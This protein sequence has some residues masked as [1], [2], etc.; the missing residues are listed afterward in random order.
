MYDTFYEIH[1]QLV[2]EV[3]ETLDDGLPLGV[4]ANFFTSLSRFVF[5]PNMCP[6]R[7]QLAEQLHVLFEVVYNIQG[8]ADLSSDPERH[9][10][11]R[12]I[13]AIYVAM[14]QDVI[15]IPLERQLADLKL[16]VDSLQAAENIMKT[17][18]RHSFS[19]HCVNTLA[20]LKYC[21]Y[22][23]GYIRFKP[24]LYFCMN[25]LRGCLADI[26]DLHEDFNVFLGKLTMF[27]RELAPQLQ[28]EAFIGNSLHHITRFAS[29]MKSL[30]LKSLVSKMH[31]LLSCFLCVPCLGCEELERIAVWDYRAACLSLEPGL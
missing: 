28:P 5:Y 27:A 8:G 21:A 10:C 20:R 13:S 6:L 2:I 26:A 12:N 15:L 31:T 22:C 29:D 17:V 24:C 7:S 25:S 4:F 30:D 9:E 18:R 23:G 11:F 14:Y 3:N 16:L 19:P 1:R